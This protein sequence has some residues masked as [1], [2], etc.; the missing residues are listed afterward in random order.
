[1]ALKCPQRPIEWHL[2]VMCQP[3]KTICEGIILSNEKRPDEIPSWWENRRGE[4]AG[5]GD[6]GLN[7]NKNLEDLPRGQ[8]KKEMLE[9]HED[10]PLQNKSPFENGMYS[11]RPHTWRGNKYLSIF[12][13]YRHLLTSIVQEKGTWKVLK[14]YFWRLLK[15]ISKLDFQSDLKAY[16]RLWGWVKEGNEPGVTW[17]F[18]GKLYAGARRPDASTVN[19]SSSRRSKCS[20]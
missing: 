6:L 10:H 1:M 20:A 19:S 17:V 4:S 18:R 13:V 16:H 8:S 5:Q 11:W 7:L 14:K 2:S 15:G 12:T 3:L 9:I